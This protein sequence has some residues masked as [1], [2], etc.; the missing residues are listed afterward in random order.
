MGQV[1][2]AHQGGCTKF[3]KR[4]DGNVAKYMGDGVFAYF[5]WPHAH[6]DDAERAVRSVLALAQAAEAVGED[7]LSRMAFISC[8]SVQPPMPV[9]GSGVMFY[10]RAM[11]AH[12]SSMGLPPASSGPRPSG[13]CRA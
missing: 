7:A 2:R 1:I 5:G 4:W 6:E 3:I 9:S 11:N 13:S 8:S 10:G 12:D